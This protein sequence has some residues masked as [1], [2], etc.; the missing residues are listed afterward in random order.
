MGDSGWDVDVSG[1]TSISLPLPDRID[2]RLWAKCTHI[3]ETLRQAT[4]DTGSQFSDALNRQTAIRAGWL[5]LAFTTMAS[6]FRNTNCSFFNHPRVDGDAAA[7]TPG[8]VSPARCAH[9]DRNSC[10]NKR[11]GVAFPC[12][13]M[14]CHHADCGSGRWA[15]IIPTASPH[16]CRIFV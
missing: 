13:I 16:I 2:S 12:R 3:T 5:I 6:Y 8:S 10:P 15:P 7:R 14:S 9:V 4:S 1:G 11:T